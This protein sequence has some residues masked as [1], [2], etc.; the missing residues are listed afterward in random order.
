M[1]K[2]SKKTLI[3]TTIVCLLPIIAGILL[4]D[5]MPD[6]IV[7]HWDGNGN[8]NGWSSKFTGAIVFPGILL[9]I[10][11]FFPALLKTDPKYE[12]LSDKVKNLIH[13]IIPL[14]ALFA[15]TTTL[16]EAMGISVNVHLVGPMILGLVFIIIGNYLPKM[17]QSYTVGIKLPWTLADEENWDKTH[18]MAG[19]LWVVGG[20]LIL[21]GAFLPIR[22]YSTTAI[23]ILM[24]LVPTVYSYL[25][26]VKKTK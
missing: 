15:S 25:L 1:K 18:R 5:K 11:L 13:W 7:T 16:A 26:W 22:I 6:Q 2:E 14:V 24:V 3:L 21:I 4:Y 23:I 9:A 17:S 20:I 10:N 19:Y 12:N 8:P